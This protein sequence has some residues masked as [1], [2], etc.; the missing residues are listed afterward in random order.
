M[1]EEGE[2]IST[3]SFRW[4]D[5]SFIQVEVEVDQVAVEILENQ[6]LG[7]TKCDS[8]E[9]ILFSSISKDLLNSSK[10]FE[11]NERLGLIYVTHP[12]CAVSN[13]LLDTYS[14]SANG[15]SRNEKRIMF[16]NI[17]W[18]FSIVDGLHRYK[19]ILESSY[20]TNSI[21]VMW[22]IRTDGNILSPW[23]RCVMRIH[24]NT[25][26]KYIARP[27]KT[28]H[29]IYI[30]QNIISFSSIFE[31]QYGHAIDKVCSSDLA[32]ELQTVKLLE[33]NHIDTFF[34]YARVAQMMF[35]RPYL[36]NL[37]LHSYG[38]TLDKKNYSNGV[39]KSI[40][41]KSMK[42][43]S[44][45]KSNNIGIGIIHVDDKRL[46]FSNRD[47]SILMVQCVIKHMKNEIEYKK[48]KV[49]NRIEK[50]KL[51]TT[52][53]RF[54][55]KLFYNVASTALSILRSKYDEHKEWF[56][57]SITSFDKFLFCKEF[58]LGS[59]NEQLNKT[60]EN[61]P[62]ECLLDV[63]EIVYR[64]KKCL[65][66][67][68]TE[69][70]IQQFKS[71]IYQ[72]IRKICPISSSE[73][74]QGYASEDERNGAGSAISNAPERPSPEV[75]P[76]RCSKSIT[77]ITNNTSYIT[78]SSSKSSSSSSC[79]ESEFIAFD[80]FISDKVPFSA[81]SLTFSSKPCPHAD[82]SCSRSALRYSDSSNIDNV[83]CIKC[84]Q[85]LW[86]PWL[87]GKFETLSGIDTL[88]LNVMDPIFIP[89][90]H[91]AC[92]FFSTSIIN[93]LRRTVWISA[94]YLFWTEYRMKCPLLHSKS[95]DNS[96]QSIHE[97]I[98]WKTAEA[99]FKIKNSELQNKGYIILSNFFNDENSNN[100]C[101][102]TTCKPSLP[103]NC[104]TSTHS[105]LFQWLLHTFTKSNES[106]V[107]WS[108]IINKD[109]TAA[110]ESDHAQGKARYTST[111]TLT[112]EKMEERSNVWTAR[113]R[114][115]IDLYVCMVMNM[116]NVTEDGKFRHRIPDSG[117]RFLI[118]GR[119]VESQV[120]HNDFEPRKGESP[121]Y[122]VI[123]SGTES[124]D[125]HVSPGSHHFV[126]SSDEVIE[127]MI[128]SYQMI[129]IQ[130]PSFSMFIGHGSLQHAGAGWNGNYGLRYHLYVVPVQ[131]NLPDRIHYSLGDSLKVVGST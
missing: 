115:M 20:T 32:K 126:F 128:S 116:L 124:V 80:D 30:V 127:E 25:R 17:P 13:N 34:R 91:R 130:I 40:S 131:Y 56:P 36:W 1:L 22:V 77:H 63:T 55:P 61:T 108:P 105:Q 101:S 41:I 78:S 31:G 45:Y 72:C 7:F 6:D 69:Y 110:D 121:G 119:G 103:E 19:L 66:P 97:S 71:Y 79:N 74:D 88:D 129:T 102:C 14:S 100:H 94:A 8:S 18:K 104:P 5:Y 84:T 49:N 123:V 106:N 24:L 82:H 87:S 43:I 68:Q 54:Q 60:R 70:Y 75:R 42:P 15:K 65:S 51:Y 33:A 112:S 96:L 81:L 76:D 122:F 107:L 46:R 62:F 57:S 99:F 4:N 90:N 44:L 58:N 114:A 37:I 35:T 89:Q 73:C 9:Q 93:L 95:S 27:I 67:S 83:L 92:V 125:L 11:Y 118:N 59:S 86:R 26:P 85:S 2:N 53:A 28:L 111:R 12:S 109:D 29:W 38:I 39:T 47:D 21:T 52:R 64:P 16:P 120:G 3:R 10:H 113:H 50:E 117:G 98:I 48:L 23:E